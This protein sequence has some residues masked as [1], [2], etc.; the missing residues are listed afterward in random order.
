MVLFQKLDLSVMLAYPAYVMIKRD[1]SAVH[2]DKKTALLN[3]IL[4]SLRVNQSSSSQ[5]V[6]FKILAHTSIH[7]THD[8][9]VKYVMYYYSYDSIFHDV[10]QKL[11][12]DFISIIRDTLHEQFNSLLIKSENY[13][14]Q[15]T[16]IYIRNKCIR[17]TSNTA[18]F[19]KSNMSD[20]VVKKFFSQLETYTRENAEIDE[21]LALSRIPQIYDEETLINVN[22]TPKIL[23]K[24]QEKKGENYILDTQVLSKFVNP[25]GM[26]VIFPESE[27]LK[28]YDFFIVY[29]H[30][31]KILDCKKLYVYND[32]ILN[33]LLHKFFYYKNNKI[34]LPAFCDHVLYMKYDAFIKDVYETPPH[35]DP[36][37]Y[38]ISF[39]MLPFVKEKKEND[40]RQILLRGDD[41]T[42]VVITRGNIKRK[43]TPI[44]NA[45]FPSYV[46]RQ[47]AKKYN[48]YGN[49][50]SILQYVIEKGISLG[51]NENI[52]EYSSCPYT[53]DWMRYLKYNMK[54]LNKALGNGQNE[55]KPSASA[56]FRN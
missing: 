44:L 32:L 39:S 50:P 11:Q 35:P 15:C 3:F 43:I 12:K 34:S 41:N 56:D 9:V 36:L 2:R 1:K 5:E 38:F 4:Q 54:K 14:A 25:S 45:T 42:H 47:F 10:L 22:K 51:E 55:L 28:F 6:I 37:E 8:D 23:Q 17:Y 7:L 24:L 20:F 52:Q 27:N 18:A 40:L 26:D 29:D 30:S 13:F 46:K 16:N 33:A 48:F 49:L 19:F 53:N 21:I 31:N